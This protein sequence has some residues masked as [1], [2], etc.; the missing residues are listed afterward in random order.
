MSQ[1]EGLGIA[2]VEHQVEARLVIF[3]DFQSIL[4]I[5]WSKAFDTLQ[6]WQN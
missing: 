4:F 6:P 1:N 2:N 3:E 5:D